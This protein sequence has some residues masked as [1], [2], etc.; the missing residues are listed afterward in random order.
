MCQESRRFE[1]HQGREGVEADYEKLI[2]EDRQRFVNMADL[3]TGSKVLDAGTGHGFFALCI[4]RRIKSNGLLVAIDVSSEHVR[5]ANTLLKKEKLGCAN[6]VKADLRWVPIASDSLDAVMS[7]DFLCSVNHPSALPRVFFEAKRILKNEGAM[8]VVDYV[9][10]PENT[11]ESLFY[12][13]FSIF[14]KVY[15][16]TGDSLHLTFF[17]SKKIESM[18]RKLGFSVKTEIVERDIWMPKSALR[19]EMR[20]L[21]KSM[22][23]E[24][25]NQSVMAQLTK[26]LHDFYERAEERKVRIP[27]AQLITGKLRKN[28]D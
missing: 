3:K 23:R 15:A 19:K 8:I 12:Q 18:L 5:Q 4:A 28:K 20:G 1:L 2:I 9:P 10:K 13:R 21:I 17:N 11:H 22:K 27:S 7:Y 6:V 14:K 26:E 24:A 25:V 16:D